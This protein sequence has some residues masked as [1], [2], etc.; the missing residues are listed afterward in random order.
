MEQLRYFDGRLKEF[1]DSNLAFEF[2]IPTILTD[3]F[4]GLQKTAGAILQA[5][6]KLGAPMPL[7]NEIK[8][9]RQQRDD[10]RKMRYRTDAEL[11]LNVSK[12]QAS[13]ELAIKQLADQLAQDGSK[14]VAKQTVTNQYYARAIIAAQNLQSAFI[15]NKPSAQ[16]SAEYAVKKKLALT[17]GGHNRSMFDTFFANVY[18]VIEQ[19]KGFQG[20]LTEAHVT[21]K[22]MVQQSKDML[23]KVGLKATQAAPWAKVVVP[24]IIG[25]V[26][27]NFFAPTMALL[28]RKRS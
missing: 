13:D 21:A 7:D 11:R 2:K 5:G 24:A 19:A 17:E 28:G 1:D 4:G 20:Y 9:L 25:L 16:L 18:K 12:W 14:A 15:N 27:L 22:E 10:L 26:A 3:A 23:K 6:Q 8:M